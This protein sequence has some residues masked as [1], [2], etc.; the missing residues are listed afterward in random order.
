MRFSEKDGVT[1]LD[2]NIVFESRIPLAG[3]LIRKGLNDTIRKGLRRYA[4][5]VK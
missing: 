4:D 3:G 2:Y 5:S 1:H